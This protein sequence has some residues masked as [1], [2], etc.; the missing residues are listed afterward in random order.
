MKVS[1]LN[2]L[3][4]IHLDA[5]RVQADDYGEL[6]RVEW[7][8]D[9]PLVIV[10][11]FNKTKEPDGSFKRFHTSV[12]PQMTTAREAIAWMYEFDKPEDYHPDYET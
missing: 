5:K 4:A 8:D 7:K 6:Y 12:P 1:I 9:D 10:S 11:Y 2:I 3:T